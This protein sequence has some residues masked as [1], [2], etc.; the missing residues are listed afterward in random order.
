VIGSLD[1]SAVSSLKKSPYNDF[2]DNADDGPPPFVAIVVRISFI[3][4]FDKAYSQGNPTLD[5]VTKLHSF[6]S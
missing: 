4:S 5:P 3:S 6:T 2:C 1:N